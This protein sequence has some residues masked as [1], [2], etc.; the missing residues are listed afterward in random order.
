MRAQ[1]SLL[2]GLGKLML[3]LGTAHADGLGFE[4]NLSGGQSVVF[5]MG[6]NFAPGGASSESLGRVKV[7]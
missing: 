2:T 1:W 5:D 6:D 3:M 7:Q 4:G